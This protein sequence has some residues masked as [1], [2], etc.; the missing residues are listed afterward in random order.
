LEK[1]AVLAD[2]DAGVALKLLLRAA[3]SAEKRQADKITT[4][5]IPED[6]TIWQKIEQK[7]KLESLNQH[8]RLLYDIIKQ[9]YDIIKQE[10]QIRSS[11]LKRRYL[12]DCYKKQIEPVTKRTVTNYINSLIQNKFIT[13]KTFTSR[14]DRVLKPLFELTV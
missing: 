12:L 2:G 8:Q 13:G 7:A 9:V 3:L 11:T 14:N 4:K 5:D 10:G 6:K 1:I